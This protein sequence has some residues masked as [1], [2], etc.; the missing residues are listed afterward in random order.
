MLLKVLFRDSQALLLSR[1]ISSC[2]VVQIWSVAI[3]LCQKEPSI[4]PRQGGI[5]DPGCRDSDRYDSEV[6]NGHIFFFFFFCTKAV[7]EM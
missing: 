1:S 7:L 3:K 4:I 2:V 6:R 5:F